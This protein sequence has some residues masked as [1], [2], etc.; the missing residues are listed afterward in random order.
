MKIGDNVTFEW[1]GPCEGKIVNII[2]S[3]LLVQTKYYELNNGLL[4][5]S[6]DEDEVKIGMLYRTPTG[7][8]TV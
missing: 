6:M 8:I 4:E 7:F 5:I 1:D 2:G 3:V